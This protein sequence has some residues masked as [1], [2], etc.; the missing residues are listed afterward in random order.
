MA[1]TV[2]GQAVY[3]VKIEDS[4]LVVQLKNTDG[5][6]EQLGNTAQSATKKADDGF[7]RLAKG[8]LVAVAA[9]VAAIG[10]AVALNMGSAIKRFDT[11]NNSARTF[12]N[13]GFAEGDVTNSMNALEDA[14]TGLPTSLD[15]AVRGMTSLAST[16]NSISIGEQVFTS[17]NN[18]ILGF[19]GTADEVNNAVQQLSQLPMNGP[20]DAQTWLSLRNSGLTP[21]LVAMSRDMGISIDEM[22]TKFG[23]GELTVADFTKSLI[24]MNEQGGGGLTALK[25]IAVDATSG[26]GTGFG[27]MNIAIQRGIATLLDAIGSQN[28]T[29]AL[30][31]IGKAFQGL[32][33]IVSGFINIIKPIYGFIAPFVNGIGAAAVG[34]VAMAGAV[35]AATK[36]MAA[37]NVA[38]L[39]ITRH[40]IIAALSIILGLVVGIATAAGFDIMAGQ[41]DQAKNSTDE[42]N[43]ALA[44]IEKQAGGSTKA[45]DDMAKKMAD[46]AEQGRKINED[47][48]YSL[49]QLVQ[50]K[51]ENIAALRD[52]LDAEKKAYDNA[53]AK[54]LAGFDKTQ[55]EEQ[56][57]HSEKIKAFQ[58]QIDFLS[59]YN[60]A[61][62]NKQVET[63]KF[64]L[65]QENAQYKNSTALRTAEF[66]AQTQAEVSEYEKRRAENEIKLNAEL[67]LLNKHRDD[68]LGVRGV[69][70][71]DEIENLKYSRD[72]QL[73]SLEKQK[74][75]YATGGSAAGNSFGSN[76]NA[77]L[78]EMLSGIGAKGTTAGTSFSDK[79]KSAIELSVSDPK[80]FWSPMVKSFENVL[81]LLSG[82]LEVKNGQIVVKSTGGGGGGW[83]E[84]GYTGAG[85]KNEVAGLVHRGEYVLPKSMVN[86]STG[87]PKEGIGGGTTVNVNL[88]MSGVMASG[89]SDLRQIAVQ[90]GQMINETVVAKTGNKAIAGI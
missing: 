76:F 7:N 81:G 18:A 75:D 20:L 49:A 69:M 62:N 1:S 6:I 25:D 43:K 24:T 67:A 82:K 65:A 54:R 41:A 72:E 51:N 50:S 8:G 52:T 80:K 64:A 12:K 46:I 14:I 34:F 68:V 47:Y 30:S 13:I 16:Y 21:V 86:Q 56:K 22:K 38:M 89:K 35:F 45:M 23:E 66:D 37:L 15:A 40:P 90:L 26:I 27:N 70:L 84:G 74:T 77:K 87:L 31:S 9:G 53:Y 36:A 19:G 28:I 59:K 88:N 58:N 85:G 39:V 42:L 32:L 44:D 60:N 4:K 3:E 73:R 33:G 63:L 10:A 48:R 17:L 57:T 2:V 83:A 61:A 29:S 78:D 55:D 11:L 5:K 71:R 79:F